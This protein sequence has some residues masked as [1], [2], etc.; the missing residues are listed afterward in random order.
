MIVKPGVL[1]NVEENIMGAEPASHIGQQCVSVNLL[2]RD[3][4]HDIHMRHQDV[5]EIEMPAEFESTIIA[6]SIAAGKVLF[7][8]SAIQCVA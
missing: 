4:G 1:A 7:G 6:S 5:M 8:F 3:A 2:Q